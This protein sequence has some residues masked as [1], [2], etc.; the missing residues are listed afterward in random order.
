MSR[1]NSTAFPM[2]IVVVFL[3]C[4]GITDESCRGLASY[5]DIP[6]D[7]QRR[8]DRELLNFGS[9]D[10]SNTIYVVERCMILQWL[11]E[12]LLQEHPTPGGDLSVFPELARL[13]NTARPLDVN[14]A[15]RVAND[16]F[17][18]LTRIK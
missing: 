4:A 7:L 9:F 18:K 2:L 16:Y 17:D 12:L 10:V 13:H 11:S 15:L 5:A 3:G 8:M 6:I 14:E 1:S